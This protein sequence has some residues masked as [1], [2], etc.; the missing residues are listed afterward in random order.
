MERC[1]VGA[2]GKC[3]RYGR[4]LI[5]SDAEQAQLL[6]ISNTVRRRKGE[7]SRNQSLSECRLNVGQGKGGSRVREISKL[8]LVQA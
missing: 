8:I 2:L 6:A 4:N 5:A 3:V 1:D 7:K